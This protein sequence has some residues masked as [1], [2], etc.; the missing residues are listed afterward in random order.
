[1]TPEDL[2]TPNNGQQTDIP[3]D[4]P[5]LELSILDSPVKR[6]PGRPPRK[7]P[8]YSESHQTPEERHAIEEQNRLKK[9]REEEEREQRAKEAEEHRR[10]AEEQQESEMLQRVFD[11]IGEAGFAS[12]YEF[13]NKAFTTS[14]PAIS[15]RMG[16]FMTKNGH[17]F[18]QAMVDK[19]P[20]VMTEW[21]Q[22]WLTTIYTKEAKTLWKSFRPEAGKSKLSLISDFSLDEAMRLIE[23]KAPHLSKL[24]LAI[25]LPGSFGLKTEESRHRDSRLVLCTA[26]LM[27]G[28]AS[29]ERNNE[30]QTLMGLYLLACGT[31]RRQFDV[32][33]HA[34]LTVSYSTALTHLKQLSEEGMKQAVSIMHTEACAI[35]WDN[36]NTYAVAKIMAKLGRNVQGSI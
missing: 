17:T 30:F 21:S 20:H 22:E 8:R 19:N 2:R 36:L 28:Q 7:K 25:G 33:A 13:F 24:I 31:P 15:A 6:G 12:A 4:C 27:M 29:S 23:E 9:V 11:T 18:L 1:M 3:P 34:G 16:K 14:D 32:L 10:I 5:T 35:V 26:L